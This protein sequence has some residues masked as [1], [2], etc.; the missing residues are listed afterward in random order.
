MEVVEEALGHLT[1]CS[2]CQAEDQPQGC[3]FIH[4]VQIL[5]FRRVRQAGDHHQ[6]QDGQFHQAEVQVDRE[7]QAEEAN[8]Y[9]RRL[10][11][12]EVL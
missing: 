4:Q 9:H 5:R 1:L 10:G 2:S 6:A 8:G 12:Q 7:V 11:R 3:R